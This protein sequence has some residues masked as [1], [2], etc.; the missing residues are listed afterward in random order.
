[1]ENWK[2]ALSSIWGHK[3][4][5]I[6]TMLGI[7]IG[8]AAVVIIMGLGNAMK[9]SVTSTFSSKQKDIQLYF[10]EK[11]EEED[12]YAG[13]HTHENNHEVKPEWLEQIV[14]DIDGIDSY[15]F[16]NSATS[17]ISYEKKKVD[18]AS[19]IGV[20]KDYFNIKNYDIVAG[21]TLTDNDYSNFSRIILLDT[22]LAD[23]L[24]GE[25]NYKS[26]LNKVVSLSDKD[27]LVIGVYK[28]DQTPVSFDGLSGGAVM[29]NTQVA[30]EF[31][32][33]E[34][35]SIYIHVN[36]I[37]N[38][39][40]LG[41]QAADM[42]TNISHIKD[43]QYA[44]PD[45]SKI[46]EEINSQFSIMTT[47]IGSI[48]AISLLV[49]GIGVMNI[50][51]VSVTERTREIGL[52]K[53]LGATRLKI[54]SQ[55]LIESVVL[56]VLG[57]LIGLLLAQLSVG[58]LGNAMTLKGACI[59]LDVALIAVLF[60]ASIGVFFGMLPANKAS[61]LDPIEALRYE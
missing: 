20:S 39:M 15:Y 51:L 19:I 38:S 46:V 1:M 2:F 11:G 61:K 10:Q 55:F 40:N 33:K 18:N 13:F 26:A 22:V 16:T 3:M 58:A 7:I 43:G 28:T 30:S 42:L 17:T 53:A 24:F 44:V 45:N 52:R 12:L 25:G 8:V 59:S 31:G 32:T 37:Q 9:N 35:G 21:R 27:Y 47:V 4:R 54:L 48:A 29:A 50:M 34:I 60:S 14:K 23:D 56:T 57:G 36:D 49:G 6:L 41:N 5:S